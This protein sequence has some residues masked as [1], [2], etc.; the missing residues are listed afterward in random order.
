MTR[1]DWVWLAKFAI[2]GYGLTAIF[3]A[4]AAVC[5]YLATIT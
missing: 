2:V 5:L 3:A 1:K 4:M